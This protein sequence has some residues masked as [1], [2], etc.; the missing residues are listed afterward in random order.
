MCKETKLKPCPF[1]GTNEGTQHHLNG[2]DLWAVSCC[3]CNVRVDDAGGGFISQEAATAAWNK[4]PPRDSC[5]ITLSD[6][7]ERGDPNAG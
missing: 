6:D 7:P 1:C 5:T 2:W 4:R 3:D